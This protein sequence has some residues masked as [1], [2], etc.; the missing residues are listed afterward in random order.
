MM[1]QNHFM[2]P[3]ACPRVRTQVFS[4]AIPKH[5]KLRF[6]L[7]LVWEEGFF[8]I[9]FTFLPQ[10]VSRVVVNVEPPILPFH[11]GLARSTQ[12]ARRWIFEGTPHPNVP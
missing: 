2:K 5:L 1:L 11:C 7:I 9:Y 6:A 8:P 10:I 12:I 4:G 3:I